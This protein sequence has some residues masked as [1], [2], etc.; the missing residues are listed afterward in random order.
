MRTHTIQPDVAACCG[1]AGLNNGQI[2]AG[3]AYI[4][5]YAAF[6]FLAC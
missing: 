6:E 5:E 1:F 3:Y 4:K 2:P